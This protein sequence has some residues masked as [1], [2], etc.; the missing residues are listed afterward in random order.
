MAGDHDATGLGE[1]VMK[2]KSLLVWVLGLVVLGAGGYGLY[3]LGVSRGERMAV[4]ASDAAPDARG[5][6]SA[7]HETDKKILYWHDPMVPGARFDKPGKSPFMDMP[8]VPVYAN[9]EAEAGGV[10]IDPRVQQNLGL[11]AAEVTRGPLAA[12]VT[13]V[14]SVAYDERDVALVQARSNG[15]VEKLHVRAPLDPVRRGQV[16]AEL[17][18]PEWV[19]AQEEFLAVRRLSGVGLDTLRDG[20]RQRMRLAGMS[21]EQIR[22]VETSG[23]LHARLT[24]TAPIDGVV[25]EL[26]AREGMT[27]MAG[28]PLFRINGLA[29]VWVNAEVPEAYADLVRAGDRVTVRTSSHTA[30]MREGRVIAVLPEVDPATRTFKLRIEL[31]N[32]GH[33]LVPG[34]FVS[35]ELAAAAG[36]EVLQ[37]PSEAVIQTGRRSVVIVRRDDRGFVPVDVVVGREAAGLTEIRGGLQ[38]GQHVVVSGQFLID[39]EASLRASTLRMSEAAAPVEATVHRGVGKIERIGADGIVISHEPIPSL[40][41]GRMTMGFKPPAAG[42]PPSLA[43]GDR[44]A[45]E[46]RAV[47][48]GEFEIVSITPAPPAENAQKEPARGP[49]P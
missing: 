23:E 31:P 15:Y 46:I 40:H 29:T 35:V 21:D 6:D 34:L 48:E 8:L 11:R 25:T 17:Y 41:W 7:A 22:L 37:V 19:A 38:A 42:M 20:A 10:T 32:P 47:G 14:G 5:G 9:G 16:L 24:V 1:K 13:A 18:V 4:S 39:S 44:V 27:V 3:S 2:R 45:F 43:V 49:R 36:A 12:A 33:R 30:T 28:A 26:A